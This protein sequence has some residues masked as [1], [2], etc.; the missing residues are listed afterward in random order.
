MPHAALNGQNLY[1][2]VHGDSGEPL[3]CIHGLAVDSR[4]WALQIRPWSQR[5]RVVVFDNRDVGRSSYASAEYGTAD[6]AADAQA[7]AD[8]LELERF[9][10]IGVSLGGM[11]AQQLALAA[12]DRV[13]SLTI[14]FSHGG[15]ERDYGELRA[16][17]LGRMMHELSAAERVDELMLLCY[18]EDFFADRPAV[19]YL[20]NALLEHPHP[21]H[22][23]GFARQALAGGRHDIRDRLRALTMPVHVIG[24]R[25][26]ILI[27]VW[28]SQELAELIP[29]AQLTVMENVGHGAM[30][31]RAEEFNRIVLQFLTASAPEALR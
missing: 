2:D 29:G 26:D 9:H 8:N 14:A 11:V 23:D 6:M 3:L 17:L 19:E 5:H 13:A 12:P 27:P 28:K 18:T 10:L 20:R 7:L 22:P 31:E 16:R 21:Q 24:A 4:G 25:R 30:W 15:V 1:Y